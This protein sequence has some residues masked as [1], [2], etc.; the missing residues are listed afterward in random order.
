MKKDINS[1]DKDIQLG[2]PTAQITPYISSSVGI[3]NFVWTPNEYINC[4]DVDCTTVEM[5]PPFT[6][7]YLLTVTDAN[8]CVGRDEITIRVR[9]VRNVYFANAFTPNNDGYN[10]YFQA[11]IGLGVERIQTFTIFDR[12]GNRVF[13]K[14][15]YVPDPAGTDGWD[16][17]FSG[18]K[19]N[20]GVFVYYAKALFIDGKE[21]E[22]SGSVTL[23]D[24]DRN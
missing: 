10:D 13:L 16:G 17:T 6:T 1:Y 20:P 18:R 23:I 24:T 9:E 19:L 7:T 3:D 8:G 4:L 14:E 12:W 15:N 5:S 2:L 22:Y 11:V 21:I